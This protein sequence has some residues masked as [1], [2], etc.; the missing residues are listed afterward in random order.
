MYLVV[1]VLFCRVSAVCVGCE[2]GILGLECRRLSRGV[3]T[4]VEKKKKK[5]EKK[6]VGGHWV[7]IVTVVTGR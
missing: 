4:F 6:G 1:G 7:C 2:R 3:C 5:G